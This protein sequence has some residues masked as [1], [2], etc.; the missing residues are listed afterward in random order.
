MLHYIITRVPVSRGGSRDKSRQSGKF[1]AKNVA[2][3]DILRSLFNYVFK[4]NE[5]KAKIKCFY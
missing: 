1:F 2:L 3:I 5:K 4:I